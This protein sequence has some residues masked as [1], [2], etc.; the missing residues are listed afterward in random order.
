[1]V[2]YHHFHAAQQSILLLAIDIC[3]HAACCAYQR[4]IDYIVTKSYI[5]DWKLE[6]QNILV[7]DCKNNQLTLLKTGKKKVISQIFVVFT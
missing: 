6:H 1:M 2:D 4:P 7:W 5:W 3:S